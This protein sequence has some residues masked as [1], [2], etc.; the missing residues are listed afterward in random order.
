M[1][2][3]NP[4]FGVFEEIGVEKH[5]GDVRFRPQVEISGLLMRPEHSETKARP[6]PE[7][8]R[9]RPRPRPRPKK[10]L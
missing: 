8:A 10:L 6:R 4:N 5:D 1:C 2:A 7:S 3:Y 9:P